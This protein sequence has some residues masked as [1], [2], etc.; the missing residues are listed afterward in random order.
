MLTKILQVIVKI[1]FNKLLQEEELVE[2]SFS[3]MNLVTN[4]LKSKL[5]LA[6]KDEVDLLKWIN[7][8]SN[9]MVKPE[10]FWFGFLYFC[11]DISLAQA[12]WLFDKLDENK[13]GLLSVH[14]LGNLMA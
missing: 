2:P 1:R 10:E 6:F 13:D 5:R 12:L 3:T 7:L 8:A 14:E 4:N 9:H 11:A